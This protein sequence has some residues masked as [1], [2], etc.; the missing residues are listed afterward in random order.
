MFKLVISLTFFTTIPPTTLTYDFNT[1]SDCLKENQT[2]TVVL[3]EMIN[4]SIVNGYSAV[5]SKK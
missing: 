5:C 4:K 1:L 2:K 3:D